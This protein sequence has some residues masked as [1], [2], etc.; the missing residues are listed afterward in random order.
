M[1]GSE[2][3]EHFTPRFARLGV[4]GDTDVGRM[5][6]GRAEDAAVVFIDDPGVYH[7]VEGDV[8]T[9]RRR[10]TRRA[11]APGGAAASG[12]FLTGVATASRRP[13]APVA[14]T[15]RPVAGLRMVPAGHGRTFAFAGTARTHRPVT[16]LR[17]MPA[18]HGVIALPAATRM[19][20]PVGPLA[21][22]HL[23]DSGLRTLPG[24]HSDRRGG[25]MIS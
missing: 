19:R 10:V 8:S 6:D 22:T 9:R 16:A 7:R 4:L 15:H 21:S 25:M 24:G 17:I 3:L 23:P 18:G 2:S 14:L 20:R 13:I 5:G 1:T 12:R 11:G